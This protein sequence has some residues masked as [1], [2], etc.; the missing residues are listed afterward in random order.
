[1][2]RS[3]FFKIMGVVSGAALS[4]CKVDNADRKLLP[5][6]VPPGEGIIPGVPHYVRSTC[7]ECPAHCG[8]EVKLLDGHPVKLEGNPDH[9]IN[10]GALCLRGQAS[11]AR[12]YHPNRET[13]KQPVMKNTGGTW[14]PLSWPETKEILQ[15]ALKENKTKGLHNVFLSSRTTGTLNLLIDEFCRALE[16]ERLKELE[17][18]NHNEIKQAN[19][20]LFGLPLLPYYHIDQSDALLTLGVDLFETF[21]SPVEWGRQYAEAQKKNGFTRHHVEPYLTLTG[22]SA[23]RRHV[24]NP[25]SEPYLLAFLLHNL[26]LRN[27][28]P[29]DVMAM[30][31]NY[32]PDKVAEMTGLAKEA[33][34]SL[35]QTLAN[36]KQPL[37]IAGGSAHAHANGF[38]ANVYTALLQWALGMTGQTV[39]FDHAF[40]YDHVGSLGDF[41]AFIDTCRQGKVGV[42]LFSHVHAFNVFPNL[43]EDIKNVRFKVAIADMPGPLTEMCH[44]VLPLSHSLESWG[45]VEPRQGIR[46]L[47]QPAITPLRDTKSEGD[48]LLTLLG[49]EQTYRDYLADHW[50]GLGVDF[51]A[52]GYKITKIEP[53]TVGLLKRVRLENPIASFRKNCLFIVPSLRT[54]DGRGMGIGLMEEIPEPMTAISYGKWLTVSAQDAREKNLSAGDVVAI[55]TP[56]GKLKLP[57]TILPGLPPGIMTMTIDSFGQGLLSGENEFP[58]CFEDVK[59]VKTG[60]TVKIAILSGGKEARNRGILPPGKQSEYKKHTLYPPHGHEHYRWGMVVDLDLCTGCSAC[61][62]AC[63]IENNVPVVGKAEHIRGREMSWLRIEAY[64]DDPL[65]PEFIP[66]LCQHCDNAPCEAVCPVYATYHSPEGLNTQIY[67]RCVGTRYCANNCPY[68]VRRFN[69]FDRAHALP[70]YG[71]ANPEL[72]ARPKGV[73]EKCTFCMQ[74]IRMAGDRAKDEKRLIRDGE[75]I[76]ACAQTCPTGAI[77]FGNLMDPG[78]G[79]GKLVKSVGVYRIFEPLGTEPGVYYIKSGAKTSE[80]FWEVQEPFFKRVPGR[81][82]HHV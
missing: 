29:E 35:T 17:I 75:V 3:D 63:Y 21:L 70:L 52:N 60:E 24:V 55:E 45:D 40:N 39:D 81:R 12:L 62:A 22:A 9:P 27:T 14:Q 53:H 4:A 79:V 67:N 61:V 38:I 11:L 20:L 34:R 13:I 15:S 10:K 37:I 46:C 42:A 80:K 30:V 77:T 59:P 69:W 25:G 2:E 73:M 31:P 16:I 19:Q 32:P 74:R 64:Y 44:L 23:N 5:Y 68:K 36:A 58:F 78:T 56:A 49:R 33:I 7:L 50:Q 65:Q 76:P 41:R 54:F 26:N 72:S 18:Y 28:P 82:G 6:L 66:M 57:V 1:M 48:I 71:T 8:I 51:I 47:L 43:A